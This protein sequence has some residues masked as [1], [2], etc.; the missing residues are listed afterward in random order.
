MRSDSLARAMAGL[1]LLAAVMV[2]AWTSAIV[3]CGGGGEG[4]PRT[5]A[6]P[7]AHR[8]AVLVLENRSYEEVIG[9]PN[10][11]FLTALA[12]RYALA[13]RHYAITHPSLPNYIA[14]TGG[15]TFNIR[16]DCSACDTGAQNVVSQ[17]DAANVSWRAYFEELTSNRLPGVPTHEYNPHYNPFVYYERVRGTPLGRRRIVDFDALDRDL[18]RLR[19]PRFSW[20]APGVRHDGHN[21]RLRTADRFVSSLVPRVMRA[22]G[23]HGVLYVT[24]DEGRRSDRRG[25][26][27]SRGGGRIALVAVGP[28]AR[29]ATT[30]AVPSDHYALLRTIEAGFRLPPLGHAAQSSTPLLSGLLRAR[31]GR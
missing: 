20:I 10:A 29:P 23:R 26:A 3:G 21:S 2:L 17:L 27:G 16:G 31:T 22:L 14:M 8:V 5:G 13:T 19:L 24:W 9:S 7:E 6:V 28:D 1:R 11:P 15:S 18:A 4:A 30:S 25:V 12:R